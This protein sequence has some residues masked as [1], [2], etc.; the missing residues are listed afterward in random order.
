MGYLSGISAVAA[1]QLPI[2]RHVEVDGPFVARQVIPTPVTGIHL[3]SCDPKIL[4][5][6]RLQVVPDCL[7]VGTPEFVSED[8]HLH[9]PSV[10][11]FDV[12]AVCTNGPNAIHFVPWPF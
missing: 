11:L 12:A 2:A 9:G 3:V 10:N 1:E 7:A 8:L 6:R 4:A 5:A